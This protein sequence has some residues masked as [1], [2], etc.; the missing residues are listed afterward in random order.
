MKPQTLTADAR[1]GLAVITG[2]SRGL[3]RATALAFAARSVPTVL[4]ARST[5]GL[6]TTAERC[7]QLGALAHVVPCDLEQPDQ[8]D[9]AAKAI[10]ELGTV[11]VLVN[12]AGVMVRAA[13]A[14]IDLESY[15]KQMQVNL[16]AP[17]WLSRALVPAMRRAGSGRIVNVGSISSTLG[18]AGQI[19]YNASKWGLV[20]FT[21]SLA[22][23][24]SDSGV[25]TVAVLPG[26]VDTDMLLGSRF[27]PRMTA[28]DVASTLVHY[29]LDAPLAHNGAIIE[30]FGT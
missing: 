10:H 22:E 15:R 18:S 24:L 11:R 9:A 13:L 17:I 3:G 28:E 12:N 25:M 21:K 14:E 1:T 6:S 5:E 23:E 4:L 2:A 26:S 20:G 8:I 30:M 29:S 27:S 7:R 16:L 19:V